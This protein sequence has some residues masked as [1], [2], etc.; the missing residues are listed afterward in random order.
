MKQKTAT[1]SLSNLF[2]NSRKS[3]TGLANPKT[4]ITKEIMMYFYASIFIGFIG[5]SALNFVVESLITNTGFGFCISIVAFTILSKINNRSY[6]TDKE[7]LK[8]IIIES[9]YDSFDSI[10][11]FEADVLHGINA[12]SLDVLFKSIFKDEAE[13]KIKILMECTD[14]LRFLQVLKPIDREL[15]YRFYLVK[16][17]QGV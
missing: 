6:H 3:K 16:M 17:Q 13:D 2:T 10:I 7:R 9:K 15:I 4:F 1:Q 5:S 8:D 14:I 12:K 11:K